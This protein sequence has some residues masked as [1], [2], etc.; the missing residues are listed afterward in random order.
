M[1]VSLSDD[2]FLYF[3]GRAVRGMAAIVGELGDGVANAKPDVPA[4][5]RHTRC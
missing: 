3:V 4:P 5:T 2:D 1:G